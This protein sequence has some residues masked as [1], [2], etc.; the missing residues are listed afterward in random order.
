MAQWA[1]L[2][3]AFRWRAKRRYLLARAIRRRRRLR[4]VA[5][6]TAKIDPDS[7]LLFASIR[8]EAQRLPHFLQHYR[9]LGIDH[10]LIVDNGSTDGSA[11]MLAG[12]SD[13]SLWRT[14]VSYR[15]HRFGM[16]WLG[17]LLLRYGHDH[18]CL[19]VDADELLIYPH[20]D[21][22]PLRALTEWLDRSGQR[23]FPAMMLELYPKGPL[24]AQRYDPATDPTALLRW[25]DAGNYT[26]ER[27]EKSRALWIQGGPRARMFF[28]D[29]PHKAPTLTKIPL[30]RW[31]W[32]FAYLNSTHSILPPRLN[33]AYDTTGGEA[34]SGLLLHTKFLPTIVAKAAEEKQRREHFGTPDT[35]DA[36]YDSLIASP[37]FWNEHS[38]ALGGWR[39]LEALG[40]MSR[41]GWL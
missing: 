15:R 8:N 13:V 11:E 24:E 38:S 29:A 41:G 26:I 12:Q 30:V 3:Q 18:W 2:W 32:R 36:Y 1:Q 10:F 17:W 21:T 34:A 25:F 39:R 19:T 6:R 7:L 16:D 28:A 35:F 20:H 14:P 22:R 40:L 4:P 37:D 31:H 33:E 9:A 27:Q 5:N 23:V